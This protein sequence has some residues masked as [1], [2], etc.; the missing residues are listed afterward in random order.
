MSAQLRTHLGNSSCA[1]VSIIFC[2]VVTHAHTAWGSYTCCW[3][4]HWEVEL[5]V[6]SA[7]VCQ[8]V[9]NVGEGNSK[10][11]CHRLSLSCLDFHI[12]RQNIIFCSFYMHLFLQKLIKKFLDVWTYLDCLFLRKLCILSYYCNNTDFRDFV[13]FEP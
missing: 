1:V 2:L 8:H 3:L 6:C 5:S 9:W 12:T 11:F 13:V 10:K 4:I 7:H